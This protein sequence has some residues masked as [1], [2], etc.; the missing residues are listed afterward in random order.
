M[1]TLGEE[2]AVVLWMITSPTFFWG[3]DGEISPDCLAYREAYKPQS[4]LSTV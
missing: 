1:G 3:N 2:D 4:L